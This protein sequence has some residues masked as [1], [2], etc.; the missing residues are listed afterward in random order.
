[1]NHVLHPGEVGVALGR[2]TVLPSF[3]VREPL[4]APVGDVEGGIGEYEIGLEIGVA[5]VVKAVPMGNLPLDAANGEVH[6]R[7]PPGRI[8]R[9]LAVDAD[10]AVRPPA[11]AVAAGVRVDELDR[12]NEHARGA[13]AR[14]VDPAFVGLQHFDQE[15]DDAARGVEFPAFLSFRVRELR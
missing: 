3:I 6:L 10:V 7:E 5:V 12:L 1:M 9:L 15:L 2:D 14:V 13:A 11:V 4:A 8:I